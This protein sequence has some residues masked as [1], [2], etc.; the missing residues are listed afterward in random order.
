MRDSGEH[1]DVRITAVNRFVPPPVVLTL[2]LTQA[3][4]W[5]ASRPWPHAVR[6]ETSRTSLKMDS[7][8]LV[9]VGGSVRFQGV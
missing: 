6:R 7:C 9:Q 5:H 1:L 8:C 2:V 3:C 4:T